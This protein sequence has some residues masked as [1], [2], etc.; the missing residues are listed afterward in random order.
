VTMERG[1]AQRGCEWR[2]GVGGSEGSKRSSS[3]GGVG[4]KR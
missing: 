3:E 2:T 4:G 1:Q